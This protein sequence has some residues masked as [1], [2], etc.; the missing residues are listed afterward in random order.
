MPDA[1][2][3]VSITHH[4][5][6]PPPMK[7]WLISD[8]LSCVISET[9]GIHCDVVCFYSAGSGCSKLLSLITDIMFTNYRT[10]FRRFLFCPCLKCRV[11][12]N[13]SEDLRL[14]YVCTCVCF[15]VASQALVGA[16]LEFLFSMNG[17]HCSIASVVCQ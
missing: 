15:V 17:G 1:P 12:T 4:D 5:G 9:F 3:N 7:P 8:F 11:G 16:S 2:C 14:M 13:C 6:S 10:E